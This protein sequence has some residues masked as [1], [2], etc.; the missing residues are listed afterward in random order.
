MVLFVATTNT[1]LMQ[2]H[3]LWPLLATKDFKSALFWELT[4]PVFTWPLRSERNWYFA[5]SRPHFDHMW[6]LIWKLWKFRRDFPRKTES[7]LCREV[8][9]FFPLF[10]ANADNARN[11]DRLPFIHP[12]GFSFVDRGTK[13]T[14][15]ATARF[16]ECIRDFSTAAFR[17]RAPHAKETRSH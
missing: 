5:N 2:S 10:G 16:D 14:L 13:I 11:N 9:T 12:F 17:V 15:S 6:A 3:A 7:N 1:S 4:R 8:K